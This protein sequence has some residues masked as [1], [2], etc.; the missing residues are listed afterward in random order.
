MRSARRIAIFDHQHGIAGGQHVDESRFHAAG[1]GCAE[2]E[3]VVPRADD[4][5]QRLRHLIEDDAKFRAAMRQDRQRGAARTR[6]GMAAGP[7]MRSR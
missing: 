4:V 2:Q 1:A 6:S 7:G 5:P 3:D